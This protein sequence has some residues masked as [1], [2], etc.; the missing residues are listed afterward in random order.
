[1]LQILFTSNF[2]EQ[3]HEKYNSVS[4]D[5]VILETSFTPDFPD[6]KFLYLNRTVIN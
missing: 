4:N 3:Y 5:R 6:R 2:T 1:M